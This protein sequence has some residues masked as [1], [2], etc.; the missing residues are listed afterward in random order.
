MVISSY[1]VE[2]LPEKQQEVTAGLT[3]LESEGVEIHGQDE[4]SKIVI[5]IESDS[6]DST[7]ALATKITLLEG[8][9]NTNL[10]YCNF[11]DEVL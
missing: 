7:Y 6:V 11:E 1:V 4:V 2:T 9:L 5:T 3:A 10:V 8:V